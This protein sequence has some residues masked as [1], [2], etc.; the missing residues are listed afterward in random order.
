VFFFVLWVVVVFIVVR[1]AGS[2]FFG[3]P[4]QRNIVALAVAVAFAVGAVFPSPV[5]FGSTTET[6]SAVVMV[7]PSPGPADTSRQNRRLGQ[8]RRRAH[9]RE[10][11]VG[12][13]GSARTPRGLRPHRMGGSSRSC[14][15]RTARVPRRRR[16]D[17]ANGDGLLWFAAARRGSVIRQFRTRG[18]GFPRAQAARYAFAGQTSHCDRRSDAGR[19]V[20][21]RG[22]E[23]NYHFALTASRRPFI[24]IEKPRYAVL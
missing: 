7:S 14:R 22:R 21:D 19:I 9:R 20:C 4:R 18:D 1:A 2:R 11:P 6:P 3:E 24:D 13:Q 16:P 12:D 15:S 17:P 23:A 5:R 8:P 10:R